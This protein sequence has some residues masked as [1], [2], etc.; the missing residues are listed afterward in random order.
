M[1][2]M[3]EQTAIL[4]KGQ[5]WRLLTGDARTVLRTLPDESVNCC[6]S[7][8]PYFGLRDYGVEGQIGLEQSPEEYVAQIVAVFA[9]VRRILTKDGTLW[10]NLGDSFAGS[11]KGG[12]RYIDANTGRTSRNKITPKHPKTPVIEAIKPKDLIGIPWLVAFALRAD[13]W[14]LRSDII[15][16]KPNPMPESVT[17][18]PTKAHEYLFFLTKSAKYFYDAAA[19]TEERVSDTN[20]CG[21]NSRANR[22]HVPRPFLK[23]DLINKGTYTGFNDRW[24]GHQTERRN[25]RSVWEIAPKPFPDA[26]FA[27]FP[28]ELVRPCIRAGCPVGGI[29][30][31]PFTGSGTTGEV[32]IEEGRRFVGV[33]LN[34]KYNHMAKRRIGGARLA[35]DFE[36]DTETAAQTA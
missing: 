33:E 35:F 30:I 26:H 11:G 6:V 28:P 9:E 18:R 12:N 2:P 7:S 4:D 17:D 32:A 14:Y 13:G 36:T 19:I 16:S 27:T 29:V 22:D 23:Q 1:L 34:P 3:S 24:R 21:P 5:L 10:L 25:K 31:D 15:W 20:V 8:P